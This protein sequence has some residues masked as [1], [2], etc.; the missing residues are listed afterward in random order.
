MKPCNGYTID[1]IVNFPIADLNC[2]LIWSLSIV[3]KVNWNPTTG[4][5]FFMSTCVYLIIF[6]ANDLLP[7]Y[8][9]EKSVKQIPQ[10]YSKI[11]SV[12]L[13]FSKLFPCSHDSLFLIHFTGCRLWSFVLLPS[14]T[15]FTVTYHESLFTALSVIQTFSKFR[16]P[17]VP[18]T[19]C[20][21]DQF[22]LL[23]Y[24]L[25][26]CF[27]MRVFSEVHKKSSRM[28]IPLL[29]Q[30]S[31]HSDSLFTQ[32]FKGSAVNPSLGTS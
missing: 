25:S 18:F 3:L 24:L 16:N 30:C 32:V 8:L 11:V 22:L 7:L 19:G 15:P 9:T 23:K 31:T 27:S 4:K 28:Q 5:I 10:L 29:V 26:V 2:A 12:F 14:I 6:L 1:V 20:K 21:L 17:K 13:P